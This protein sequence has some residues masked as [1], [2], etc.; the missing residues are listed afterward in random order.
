M[1]MG[2]LMFSTLVLA[3]M[4]GVVVYS[5]DSIKVRLVGGSH[6]GEGRV[7]VFYNGTWGTVCDDDWDDNDAHVVCRMFGYNHNGWGLHDCDHSEDASVRCVAA[8]PVEVR[9]VGSARPG[10]GRVEVLHNG[11][12]GTVCDDGWD[13]LDASVVCRMLGYNPSGS[14]SIPS[15]HFGQGTGSILMD[16]VAC[17]GSEAS[18]KDCNH[19]G[20]SSHKCDHSE[21][22][23]VRCGTTT[24]PVKVTLVGGSRVGEG[25]VNVFHNGE[26]GTVCDN[27]WDDNDARVV[28][29]MLGYNP[30]YSVSFYGTYFGRGFGPILMDNVACSG[31]E[32]SI[33]DCGHR[34]WRS[35]NCSHFEDA[36]V[37]CVPIRPV[38]VR[39]VGGARA[40]EGRV[41]VFLYGEW[42]TV[43]DDGWDDNDARVVCRM[44]GYNPKYS[45]SFN[46]TYFGRGFGPILMD[47]VACSGSEASIQDCG[48]NG[49]RSHDCDHFEDAGVRCLEAG[50]VVRLVGGFRD[51][52]G[53]VEVLHNGEWGTVCDDGWDDND[54]RVV[55]RML[56]YNPTGS[57]S[58][59][60][61]QFG[62]GTGSILMDNVDCSG[63]ETSIKDCGHRGWKT[64]NCAHSE[65]AGVRCVAATPFDVRLVGG[66]RVGEG[67]VEVFYNHGWGT[68]CDDSWDNNGASVVCRMLGYNGS[69][70]FSGARFGQGTGSILMDNVV[71][72]GSETSIKDC[73]H[74]GWGTHNCDH[75]ED[76]GVRCVAAR[77]VEVRLVGGSHAGEGRVEVFHNGEWG[78][79]CDDGWDV[80]DAR[81]VCRMLGYNPSGSVSFS[82]A[83]FGQGTGPIL[84]DNVACS[85]SET[86]IKDCKHR[87]WRTHNC[88]HS[89]DAGVRCVV[90][91]PVAVVRLVDGK[92]D[93][94]GRVE[95]FHN[96]EWGTVC[97]DGWDD[98]DARVVCKMLGY[99]NRGATAI[100][101]ASSG[102]GSGPI[103]MGQV[104]CTG[105]ESSL[106]DCPHDKWGT[107]DCEHS[108]DAGVRCLP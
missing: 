47:N 3:L 26:W 12:W 48:H 46:G 68:V 70:S 56:G 90:A 34:G 8:V 18:I 28:C 72:S 10:E 84:M 73:K 80:N 97:D 57:V 62:Q 40:G 66:S 44:L 15:A 1:V 27:D 41:E 36:G 30:K 5:M 69:V 43:C 78:T 104:A 31:N 52:E 25:R 98:N 4:A 24:T 42:G 91:G 23:S 45:V 37:R 55:C 99:N 33:Q 21:D 61:A 93:G 77:P 19:S 105:R 67:R 14:V 79:V 100:R 9:L 82:G 87:G 92:C 76:A 60:R 39:L 16:E 74:R 107:Q 29:R 50:P 85:G 58:L 2:L 83:R 51:T 95:V 11:E 108:E 20:W 89:K 17:T 53:R 13:D 103:H 63:I 59:S 35:H 75:S 101:R 106:K 64:H 54:A 7:E 32:A 71:C 88:D 6:A 94:E 22:A 65:D 81:V 38:E 49:W 102:R 96:G 86:S